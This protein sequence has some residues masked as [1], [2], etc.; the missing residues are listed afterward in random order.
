MLLFQPY[1]S[2]TI[3][4]VSGIAHDDI[5]KSRS[6]WL[7]ALWSQPQDGPYGTSWDWPTMPPRDT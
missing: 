7:D 1:E 6:I 3:F 5:E 4:E 2:F